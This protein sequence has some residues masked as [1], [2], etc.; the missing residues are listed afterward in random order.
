VPNAG[1]RGNTW[2]DRPSGRPSASGY[3]GSQVRPPP[4]CP[5]DHSAQNPNHVRPGTHP[6]PKPVG[7]RPGAKALADALG[8]VGRSGQVCLHALHRLLNL[9]IGTQPGRQV[10]GHVFHDRIVSRPVWAKRLT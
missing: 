8:I 10:A 1:L 9:V 6:R 5:T 3:G 7:H 4:W 2:F